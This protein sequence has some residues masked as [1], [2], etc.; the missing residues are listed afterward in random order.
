MDWFLKFTREILPATV[1]SIARGYLRME[2]ECGKTYDH[3]IYVGRDGYMRSYRSA[4]AEAELEAFFDRKSYDPGYVREKCGETVK[5]FR[6]FEEKQ[7]RAM[8]LLNAETFTDATK[9]ME[10]L[11]GVYITPMFLGVALEKQPKAKELFE[12]AINTRHITG[13]STRKKGA[14]GLYDELVGKAA[15]KLEEKTKIS[16]ELLHYALPDELIAALEGK[17]PNLEELAK[18]KKCWIILK[19]HG[20]LFVYSGEEAERFY[21][22]EI[23]E[24][25]NKKQL[26]EVRGTTV[27]GKG[28]LKGIARIVMKRSQLGKVEKGDVVITPMTSPEFVPS[29]ENASCIVTDEG[30]MTCH[31]AIIARELKKPCI[32]GTH[33]ATDVFEDGQL[34]EVDLDKGIVRK[35]NS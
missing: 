4:K 25:K 22:K 14:E 26:T 12:L 31:A 17:Q 34:V 1:Y 33:C 18:R 27:S 24:T 7:Q 5:R 9:A 13:G 15:E 3:I 6:E 20:E 19:K 16:K 28:K 30:G 32:I 2:K 29:L 10:N 8:S 11:W 23:G 21:G 35:K